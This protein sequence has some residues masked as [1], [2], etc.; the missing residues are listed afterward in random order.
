MREKAVWILYTP[1]F[2]LYNGVAYAPLYLAGV[3]PIGN[4]CRASRSGL[5]GR[6][7]QIQVIVN[8]EIS[9]ARTQRP[10]NGGSGDW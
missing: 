4:C 9:T 10:S 5:R 2:L 6:L 7:C 3:P 1:Q 8:P